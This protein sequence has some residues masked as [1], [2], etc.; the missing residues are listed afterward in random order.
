MRY[1]NKNDII[2]I[3]SYSGQMMEV[4][5]IMCLLPIVFEF[6]SLEFNVMGYVIA[7][8]ISFTFGILFDKG[9]SKYRKRMRLKHAMIVSAFIWMWASIIGGV[10]LCLVT[11]LD[12]LS[13]VFE[14]MSALTGTGITMFRNV[15]SLPLSVLFFRSF[16]QWIGGLGVIILV[17]GVMTRPG[18]A[19]AKLYQSEAREERLE[20]SI[21]STLKKTFH[22]YLIY[23]VGGIILYLIAG[24]PLFDSINA[25][26]TSISTGGMS[27]KNANMG[28]YHNDWIYLITI[29]LMILGA[30]SF[31]AHYRIIKT[32]GMSLIKDLQ[33]QIMLIIVAIGFI[34]I[35]TIYHFIPIETLFTV[36]SAITTTGASVEPDKIFNAWPIFPLI[37]IM[38]FMLIGGSS[39]STVGSIKLLRVIMFF[40]GVYKHLKEIMS[41][42]G[43]VMV[44]KISNHIIPTKAVTESGTY[45]TLFM[46]F[47]LI[48]WALFCAFGYD[49]FKSLFGIVSLQ[50]NNGLE[51]GIINFDLH[52]FLK[53]VSI[54]HMWI[55]RLE[56]FPVLVLLKTCFEVLKI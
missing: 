47:V 41:P 13:C 8:L 5:G 29:I 39:G 11:N 30:T 20:P 45:I 26:F 1:I 12:Y 53:I 50:G 44:I 28:F 43:R 36:V 17:I 32:R 6:I 42:E 4:I 49:P 3:L 18:T 56:I 16:E 34:L 51:L 48:G 23:T 25:S 15:E 55:G 14:N 7:G 35:T 46:V 24:M 31:T 33:F 2:S 27:I 9:F 38:T 37:V 10:A 54:F 40:K 22:I 19:T 21:K 52:W